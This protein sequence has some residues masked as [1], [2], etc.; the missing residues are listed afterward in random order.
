VSVALQIVHQWLC[1]LCN[2]H[3]HTTTVLALRGSY[4]ASIVIPL[5]IAKAGCQVPK[6]RCLSPAAHSLDIRIAGRQ[7][8]KPRCLSPPPLLGRV[9]HASYPFHGVVSKVIAPEIAKAD[10]QVPKPRCLSP[11]ANSLKSRIAGRCPRYP[12]LGTQAQLP[13]A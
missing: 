13:I 6:P 10:R 1:K 7:V 8:P 4:L 5:E 9:A 11:A 3:T 2:T 12:S